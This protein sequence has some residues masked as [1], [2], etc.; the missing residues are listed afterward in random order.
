MGTW[1]K[2]VHTMP[3]LFTLDDFRIREGDKVEPR[4]RA[5]TVKPVYKSMEHYRELQAEHIAQLSML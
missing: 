3:R 2:D 4:K 1:L 5:T